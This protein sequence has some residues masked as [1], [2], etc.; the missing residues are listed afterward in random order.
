MPIQTVRNYA[1]YPPLLLSHVVFWLAGTFY[2]TTECKHRRSRGRV[3]WPSSCFVCL[4]H[5]DRQDPDTCR[6]KGIVNCIVLKS[7]IYCSPVGIRQYTTSPDSITFDIGFNTSPT[8]EYPRV[9]NQM[10]TLDVLQDMQVRRSQNW[11]SYQ[12][13]LG[14]SIIWPRPWFLCWRRR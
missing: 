4:R 13:T 9:F 1:T 12:I 3:E 10:P 2:Q 14:F 11:M 6:F 7:I 5:S 8:Y